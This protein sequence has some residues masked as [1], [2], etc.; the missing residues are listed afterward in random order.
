MMFPTYSY[1]P[2]NHSSETFQLFD[3]GGIELTSFLCG[4][5]EAF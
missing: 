4:H 3:Y 1:T 2:E 5:E